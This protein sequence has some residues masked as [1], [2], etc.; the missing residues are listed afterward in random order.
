MNLTTVFLAPSL[1]ME[2]DTFKKEITELDEDLSD[3]L[4]ETVPLLP[5]V[6]TSSFDATIPYIEET[7]K[8][9]VPCLKPIPGTQNLMT[10]F[11][12]SVWLTMD[13][14][15]LLTTAVFWCA[16]KYEDACSLSKSY[17]WNGKANDNFLAV[18]L[19]DNG[20]CVAANNS[21]VLVC[22]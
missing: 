15:L 6:V 7:V 22:R 2:M 19:V 17:S 12:L 16:G 21:C 11:S 3:V 8:M 14:V 10:I 13:L 4:T 20:P 18:C 9:L 5:V 1:N